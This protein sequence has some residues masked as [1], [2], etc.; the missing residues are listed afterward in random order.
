MKAIGYFNPGPIAAPESLVDLERPEPSPGPRDLRV[1]VAAVSVNPV[2]TKVRTGAQPPPGEAR[3]LGWDAAGVVDAVGADVTL[4]RPGD[5]VFYAGAIGRPGTNAELHLVDERLVGRKPRTL[6]FTEAAALP[7]TAL[8]AWE[9]L[10]DRL[11]VP[12]GDKRAGGTILVVNGAGGVGSILTQMARRLTG[13]TVVATASRPETVAWC[14]KMGAHRVI[15]HTRPLHEGLRAIGIPQV[16]YVAGLTAT[17]RHAPAIVE[18]LAPQ[19]HLAII[20]DP[21]V[22]DIVPFK[23][24]SL[25]V[26][27]ELMFTRPLFTTADMVEQH[28]ILN[29]VSSLVD[30]GVLRTTLTERA[31]RIDAATLRRVHALVE[32]GRA[33]GKSVLTGF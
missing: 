15:D 25:T 11:R 8:T 32:S 12:H 20:D 26:S 5:E 29:E 9:L 18:S 7:L 13:L 30:D 31:G 19:G 16:E 17:D 2:D 6:D 21:K 10:F 1:R 24:K 33:I 22:F 4:F 3:I 28:R 14:Q 23:R 27:W